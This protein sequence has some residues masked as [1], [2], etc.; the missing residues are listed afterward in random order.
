MASESQCPG[1]TWHNMGPSGWPYVALNDGCPVAHQQGHEGGD[2][3][4]DA[5][6]GGTA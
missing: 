4:D 2:D 1:E 6:V 5:A 3:D